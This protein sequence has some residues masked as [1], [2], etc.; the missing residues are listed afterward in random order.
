MDKEQH[1]I[2]MLKK[3]IVG[4]YTISAVLWFV[5]IIY[6]K[7]LGSYEGPLYHLVLTPFL[8]GMTLLPILGCLLCFYKAKQW[9]GWGS[10]I[11]KALNFLGLG[12][13]GWAGGMI[14]WN[15]YLFFSKVEVP[16]PSLA[17]LFY[18][19]IWPLWTYSMIKLSVAAGTKYG[20]KNV[21]RKIVA[22]LAALASIVLSYYLLFVLAKGGIIEVGVSIPQFIL[23]LFYPIGDIVILLSALLV[24]ILSYNY[25]GGRYKKTIIILLFGFLL[26]Y[27]A[28]FIFLFTTTNGT[29][30]NG[31]ISDFLYLTMMFTISMG[32]ADFILP[33]NDV[34]K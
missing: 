34:E 8:I 5:F 31:H 14:V 1:K 17:D 28:D 9:G 2:N 10:A 33:S 24:Y 20:L 21:N 32:A 27:I 15:Y 18:I 11:G 16:F 19:T 13:L 30:F 29:Y 3:L 7:N 23:N 22:A 6:T 25:L 26:N 4:I 12:L